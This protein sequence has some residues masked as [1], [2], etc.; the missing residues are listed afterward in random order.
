M[1][2]FLCS[3]LVQYDMYAWLVKRICSIKCIYH[4]CTFLKFNME[5]ENQPLEKEVPILETIIFRFHSFN[6]RG[7][8]ASILK[9]W[10]SMM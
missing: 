7:V 3:E 1:H 8:I 4:I 9:P 2:C 5:P 10:T 6:F